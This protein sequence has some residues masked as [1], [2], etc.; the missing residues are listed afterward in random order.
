MRLFWKS[1]AAK[2]RERKEARE[3]EQLKEVIVRLLQ[4]KLDLPRDEQY[5]LRDEYTLQTAMG[6]YSKYGDFLVEYYPGDGMDDLMRV[7]GNINPSLSVRPPHD[8]KAKSHESS[9]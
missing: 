2:E 1:K 3:Q 7:G 8:W 9:R 6:Y 4:T 5:L